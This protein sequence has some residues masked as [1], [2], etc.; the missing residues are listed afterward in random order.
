MT[1][2]RGARPLPKLLDD[3]GGGGGTRSKISLNFTSSDS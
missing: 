2:D 1:E 3:M